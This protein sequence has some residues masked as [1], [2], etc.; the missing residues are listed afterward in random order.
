MTPGN[1]SRSSIAGRRKGQ[2]QLAKKR[3]GC[4][5]SNQIAEINHDLNAETIDLTVE[6]DCVSKPE[7]KPVQKE[8]TDLI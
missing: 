4:R 3:N 1:K 2:K 7:W 5:K 8:A 6:A